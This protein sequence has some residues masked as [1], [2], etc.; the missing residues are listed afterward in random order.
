MIAGITQRLDG[1]PL[2]LELAAARVKLLP[3]GSLLSRLE[4]AL[5]V[6]V[7]GARD[8][9]QRQQTLRGTIAWSY[10]SPA[11]AGARRL[12]AICSA[13]PRRHQR[14]RRRVGLRH[15]HRPGHRGPGWTS[16]SWSTR[17][18]C[19]DWRVLRVQVARDSS[20]CCP[21]SASTRSSGWPRCQSRP[22]W[23][24]ATLPP[25]WPWPRPPGRGLRGPG[26]REWLER[27]ESEHRTSRRHR[28]V[29][30]A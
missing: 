15:G 20:A 13:Y 29:R 10:A 27:L 24:R 16:R 14:R 12:L 4:H 19:A 5:P 8:L 22:S 11:R 2:A 23:R 30:P 1:L 28:L 26:E 18:C 7:E 25:S 6:L 3:P 9:P 17:A 21:W